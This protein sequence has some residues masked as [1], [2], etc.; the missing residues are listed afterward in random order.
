MN[1][2]LKRTI[3]FMLVIGAISSVSPVSYDIFNSAKA[4]AA[5]HNEEFLLKKLEVFESKS[6]EEIQLLDSEWKKTNFSKKSKRNYCIKVDNSVNSITINTSTNAS[7]YAIYKNDGKRNYKGKDILLS[8]G[9]TKIYIKTYDLK[10]D[11]DDDKNV[12]KEY[13][14]TVKKSLEDNKNS[15]KNNIG[16][17]ITELV[18]YESDEKNNNKDS[19]S[20]F[21]HQVLDNK[22]RNQWIK[23]NG[24]WQYND[25]SGNPVKYDW[26]HDTF[27]DKW[28]F[29]D[30]Y[31]NMTTGWLNKD[32]K[33][34]Y[35]DLNGEMAIGWKNIDGKWYYFNLLGKMMNERILDN[36]K[37][38]Y[39]SPSGELIE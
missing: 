25:Y 13:R 29:L 2:K 16:D 12:K 37:W 36:G 3:A 28:Y 33:W 22:K 7:Y 14:I 6:G 24:L 11:A 26:N 18:D 31:G 39:F 5:T 17:S 4:Y 20:K 34:Y 21:D 1:R 38:Y 35:F 15:L 8:D 19:L 30:S 9:I 10:S 23:V 32:N 27:N